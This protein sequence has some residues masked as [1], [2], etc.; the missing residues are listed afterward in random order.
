MYYILYHSAERTGMF[1]C[2]DFSGFTKA[3]KTEETWQLSNL[4]E[5]P[6]LYKWEMLENFHIKNRSFLRCQ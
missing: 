3:E 2:Q 4:S 5:S 6:L 1:V